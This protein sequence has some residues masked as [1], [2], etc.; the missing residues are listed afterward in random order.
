M[1]KLVFIFFLFPVKSWSQAAEIFPHYEDTA[2]LVGRLLPFMVSGTNSKV[3]N[4]QIKDGRTC[5]DFVDP[6]YPNIF[7]V[8]CREEET[9]DLVVTVEDQNGDDQVATLNN[10]KILLT[11]TPRAPAEATE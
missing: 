7:H 3:T 4:V 6:Y 2:F 9:I 10:L 5:T 11:S 1:R 8:L